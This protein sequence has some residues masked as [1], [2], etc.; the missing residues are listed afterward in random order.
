MDDYASC[1][2][3]IDPLAQY[4]NWK[5][6]AITP[7]MPLRTDLVSERVQAVF[8]VSDPVDWGRDIQVLC[9]ILRTG[10]LPGRE[11]AHQPP[12]FFANDD[13]AYQALFP[14]ERL[15]MGA[16]RIA[17]E[18]IFNRIHP[19]AMEYTSYGKP[20]PLVFKNAENVLMKVLSSSYCNNPANDVVRQPFKTLYMVG[21][22][23]SVDIKG[24]RQ[25]YS[26]G[27]L[28]QLSLSHEHLDKQ[29]VPF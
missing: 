7:E 1:F 23:P 22:N 2:E 17:L 15:G 29:S 18:S 27:M 26:F 21:D 24:A 28:C 25:V 14:A 5:K 9:D 13:L 4:K 6:Q 3:N 19:K 16:F 20:N 12:I 10:G 8:I 11:I